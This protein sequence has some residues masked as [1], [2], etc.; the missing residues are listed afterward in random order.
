MEKY[1]GKNVLYINYFITL[2]EKSQAAVKKLAT[3]IHFADGKKHQ[4]KRKFLVLSCVKCHYTPYSSDQ[5]G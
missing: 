4:S 3:E 1:N 5:N 2:K